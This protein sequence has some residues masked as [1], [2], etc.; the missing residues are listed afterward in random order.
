VLIKPVITPARL[1]SFLFVW[2]ALFVGI[3]IAYCTS[4]IRAPEPSSAN[5]PGQIIA[6]T[7]THEWHDKYNTP[8]AYVVGPRWLAGNIAYYS[9]DHPHVYI[10][11]NKKFSPWIDEAELRRKGAFFVWDPTEEYQM[12]RD[13]I[14]AR[15]ANLGSIQVMHFTWR[16]NLSMTPVEISVAILPPENQ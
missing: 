6:N 8:L 11:A 3:V 2:L 12:P 13:E 7:L 10:E 16:R 9:E 1:K 4:L 15:F 14:K 5:F